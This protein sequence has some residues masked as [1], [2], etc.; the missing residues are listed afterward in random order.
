MRLFHPIRPANGLRTPGLP[1][2]RA[3]GQMMGTRSLCCDSLWVI[4]GA[5]PCWTLIST[6][7]KILP[8]KQDRLHAEKDRLQNA[9]SII[10]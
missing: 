2:S 3:K 7:L 8:V 10:C 1:F 9:P 6:R 5:I 4:T